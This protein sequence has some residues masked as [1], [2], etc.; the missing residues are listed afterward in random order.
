MSWLCGSKS[1]KAIGKQIQTYN[2][3]ANLLIIIN[4]PMKNISVSVEG[5]SRTK[6]CL[7][8]SCC[9]SAE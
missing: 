1:Q 6:S 5:K 4:F 2:K 7:V 8:I 9:H 3:L